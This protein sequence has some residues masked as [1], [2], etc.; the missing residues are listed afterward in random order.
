MFKKKILHILPSKN[1][2]YTGVYKYNYYLNKLIKKKYKCI[3]INEY[4]NL[5]ICKQFFRIF[6]F[7]IFL[8][9]LILNKKITTVILPEENILNVSIVKK[10]IKVKIVCVI[11]DYRKKKDFKKLKFLEKLKLI[12]LEFNYLYLNLI[13]KIIVPSSQI[14]KKSL[15]NLKIPK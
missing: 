15:K 14:K 11:H 8:I 3:T 9:Y 6:F 13:D 5:N 4:F 10:F 2:K 12:Y 1:L 7:P